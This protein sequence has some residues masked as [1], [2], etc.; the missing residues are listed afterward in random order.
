M[1]MPRKNIDQVLAEFPSSMVGGVELSDF[2]LA[3]R[4][5]SADDRKEL[6]RASRAGEPMTLSVT[7]VVGL[8]HLTT[9][10]LPKRMRSKA[11]ANFS[12]FRNEELEALARSFSGKLFL[13]DHDCYS[14]EA[15]G[16]RIIESQAVKVGEAM[17][18]HQRLELVK[19]WA[20]EDALDG[21][22]QTFSIGWRP[23]KSG[24]N[25]LRESLLCSVCQESFFD[26]SHY[27]GDE[28]DGGEGNEASIV[29]ALWVNVIGAE[30]SEV[31]FPAVRGTHVRD[32]RAALAEARLSVAAPRAPTPPETPTEESPVDEILKA[33]G[34][35]DK[36]DT[37][38]ALSA[39]AAL[40]ARA[41]AAETALEE[42]KAAQAAAEE[43]RDQARTSLAA[44][45]T[46]AR[47][48]RITTLHDRGLAEMRLVAGSKREAHWLMVVK[49]DPDEAEALLA[50][51]DP[52][53]PG[54]GEMQSAKAAKGAKTGGISAA[55]LAWAVKPSIE[56]GG[57]FASEEEYIRLA[58]A[59]PVADDTGEEG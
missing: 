22:M 5:V 50:T 19:P 16:G 46:E 10:P 51:Y 3:D 32:I 57:G 20:I 7:A 29:E 23:K 48:A 1:P 4:K 18:F 36:A 52:V 14:M 9:I 58:T 28:V 43:E 27:P 42:A 6:L 15:V 55:E 11:N 30:T 44:R 56:G 45:E 12:R 2:E 34:L 21:T 40:S 33:L 49:R 37:K 53:V 13:R 31:P 39:I 25:G 26:C 35:S 47:Q 59:T 24:W 17:Q 54:A 38:A 8:Q 41:A